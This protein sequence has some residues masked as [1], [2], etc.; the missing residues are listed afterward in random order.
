MEDIGY[1]APAQ[2]SITKEIALIS[3]VSP[4]DTAAVL[5]AFL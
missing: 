5:E 2:Y 3:T 4:V 1:S